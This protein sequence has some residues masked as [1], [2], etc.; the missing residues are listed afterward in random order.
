MKIRRITAVAATLAASALVLSAC[1]TPETEGGS[2]ITEDT[3][4]S[5]A[6]NQSFYEYNDDS[7]TGNA[8]AN[9]IILYMMNSG[10]TYYDG[11]LNLAQDTSFGT[12]EKTSD[13]PLTVEYTVD[14]DSAWSDGTPV[15]AADMLLFWAAMSGHFN[16][17]TFDSDDDG[18]TVYPEDHEDAGEP[19]PEDVLANQVFF[20]ATNPNMTEIESMTVSED[21]KSV[22]AVYAS[23]FADWELNVGMGVPAHVV[24]MHA[25]DIED[26]MEAKQALID[27]VEGEDASVL[28]PIADFWNTGFQFG[29]VLPDDESLYLSSGPYL[30]TD[31]VRD[32]Y[33]TLEAN[34][35]YTGDLQPKVETIIV[36]YFADPM[37]AV[38]ALENGEVHLIQPQASSDTLQAL[39][40]LGDGFD[41][42]TGD[43][44]TYEHVDLMFANGGPFDPATYGGDE[45]T[46]LAVRQ[47]FL[48]L[49][50]RQDIVDR[51]VAPLNPEATVRSSFNAIPGAPNY[52]MLVE[53]NQMDTAFPLEIDREGAAQLLEDAGVETPV[54]VRFLTASDNPRRMD[55]LALITESVEADGLFAINDVSSAEWGS[56]LA[57]PSQYDASMFGWQST[58]TS[59]LNSRSTF[60]T[61]GGNNFGGFS[62]ARVDELWAEIAVTPDFDQQSEYLAEI[63]SILVENA[64]GASLYQHPS[65][66]GYNT[67]LQNVSSIQVSPTMFWNYWEWETTLT[68]DDIVEGEGEEGEGDS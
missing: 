23:P 29:D 38:Q 11:D 34:P 37:A 50:P 15:D 30:M 13:D 49:I 24:A 46:A 19:V 53:A 14:D 18:V 44:A 63:E 2:G 39:E 55:Q 4:L 22:T 66:T 36:R 25:L 52:D 31:F 58:S 28:A 59:I 67:D 20:N 27:A 17:A 61:G 65:I 56:M 64:F 45:E 33:V 57:D 35:D 40:G 5:V 21:G 3:A 7:A 10:F 54:E 8:T 42:I 12:Y 60:E 1:E 43:G 62:D 6:W 41:V 9:A 26:P 32:Q 51:V 68:Q 47:A 16:T 48:K